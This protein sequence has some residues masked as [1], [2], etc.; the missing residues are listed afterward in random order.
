[1]SAE[2]IDETTDIEQH[3]TQTYTI[4][5]SIDIADQRSHAERHNPKSSSKDKSST[6]ES[7]D[8]P[9]HK[10]KEQSDSVGGDPRTREKKNRERQHEKGP[11]AF[12]SK[13]TQPIEQIH[14]HQ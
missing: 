6:K 5:D 7:D 10:K 13:Q 14:M 11:T 2:K 8:E 9:E 4:G 3:R 1:M 12:R